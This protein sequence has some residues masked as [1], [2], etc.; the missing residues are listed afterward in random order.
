[1]RA[2]F[3]TALIL[4]GVFNSFAQRFAHQSPDVPYRSEENPHYWGHKKPYPGYWQQDVHY[5]IKARV[6]DSTDIIHGEDYRLIYYNNS[7]NKI[8]ELYFNLHQNAFQPSSY[9]HGL[10]EN[11]RIKVEFGKYEAQGLGTTFENLQVNGEGVEATLDNTTLQVKLNETLQPG[12][13]LEVTMQFKTYF[14]TGTMRRRMKVFE[15]HGFKH[16]DG[17]HWYPQ[18][19][20]YDHKAG[21]WANEQH[22]DKEFYNNFG[23]FDIELTFPHDYI[24]EAT[25]VLVN[26]EEVMPADLREKLDL[27]NFKDK[28]LNEAPSIIIPR[29]EGKTKTW[30]FHAKNVHNFAFTADPMYRIGEVNLDGV[31]VIALAQEPHASKWQE[32]AI[33]TA[34]V[35]QVNGQD[36]GS[37]DWPKIIVAD[38]KDGMEYPMLTLN[39]GTY[40]GHQG[41]L[42]HEVGHMWFYGMLGTNETYRAFMDEGFTQFLTVWTMD[43]IV[44]EERQRIHP[45]KYVTRHL[46]PSSNRY[47]SLYY[48][49]ILT[50]T[51]GYDEPLNT[52]SAA[53]NGAI[54]HGGN[55]GL[56]YYKAGVML[57]NLRYV[58][59]EQLF[60]EAMQ[61]YVNQWKFAHPY[62][63]D[64]RRSIMEYTQTDLNW[65][66]DQW[67]ETTKNID[68]GIKN[69]RSGNG[70][71]EYEI[72]FERKG[73]MQMP[74]DFTVTTTDGQELKYYIPNTWFEKETDATVLPKWYGWDKIQ[75]EYTAT[76]KLPAELETVE[77]DPEHYLAD[78]DL[79]DNKKGN[80]GIRT[81]SFDHRVPNLNRWDE[82]RNYW[83]PD[84][85]FN[86]FDG[87]Q[88]GANIRGNYMTRSNYSATFW[89]NTTLGGS[90]LEDRPSANRQL[91]AFDLENELSLNK[92]WRGLSTSQ[93][94]YYNA[95]IWKLGI[96]L[97]KTFR[98]QDM[99]N[100]RY[101]QIFFR[102][103]FLMNDRSYQQYLLLPNHWGRAGEFDRF[104]NSFI[105]IGFF[106]N[107][108]FSRGS[109]Q[110]NLTVRTPSI[111]SDFN[112]GYIQLN[113]IN[114]YKVSKLE[115]RSR[116]FGQWGVGEF[117]LESAL[118]LAGANPEGLLEN[119]ATRAR[120]IVPQQWAGFGTGTNNFHMGGGLNLRGYS[121]YLS[122]DVITVDGAD[123]IV[124][125][126]VGN[127]GAAIN[128]EM[129]FD[130]FISFKPGGIFRYLSMDTYLFADAGILGYNHTGSFATGRFRM[131]AGLGTALK[132]K[133]TPLKINPLVIRFDMPLFLNA[134]PAE[135]NHFQ[136][137]YV[138]GISRAF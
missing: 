105:D 20:V 133:F 74:I 35:I 37:Y 102:P 47:E 103:G 53:F 91:F 60:K 39:G 73:R 76:V 12:D 75:P 67:L 43:K 116:I 89:V 86:G 80:S 22:L 68:Y 136:F 7:P 112:Y 99:K 107:Y 138:L 23:A 54:R 123:T 78:I 128:L 110:V 132:I 61:H 30:K 42:A 109:G 113:Q 124:F 38:A 10:N 46:D 19:A 129:D 9:Y 66:F 87:L 83:R 97:E 122:P 71:S 127:S 11:N 17:V 41:L 81:L 84:L 88:L 33:F 70:E 40:P 115:F 131:D 31:R 64:F 85:W 3:V 45:S 95:G 126:Y 14:D 98:S 13:S 28:P 92:W 117:P 72:T 18:I 108:K 118:Y 5:F 26:E 130:K 32:S 16:Y 50:A 90:S 51:E 82:Q 29:E 8:N 119:R 93:E 2:L 52:H 25:G 57:Y 104:I 1:M 34:M 59:G 44:G 27:S 65:F 55:Y 77:I 134:P 121:G 135:E 125:G 106:R 56:V 69:I 137:R 96:G 21:W 79:R 58:L 24:V 120:G 94:A 100:P 63:E 36:F 114:S 101:S 49:Y 15:E 6:D 4:L 111:G 48:P 62:P